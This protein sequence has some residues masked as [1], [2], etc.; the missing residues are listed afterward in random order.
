MDAAIDMLLDPSNARKRKAKPDIRCFFQSQSVARPPP[1]KVH[2]TSSTPAD[3]LHLAM[4]SLVPWDPAKDPHKPKLLTL[5]T[6]SQHVPCLSLQPDF[7]PHD[8]ASDMLTEMLAASADW[9]RTKW[10]IVDRGQCAL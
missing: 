7:L 5:H 3:S 6:L 10:V 9:I 4:A 2:I 1:K 8:Q